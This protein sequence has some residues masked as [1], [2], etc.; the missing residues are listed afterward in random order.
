MMEQ[1]WTIVVRMNGSQFNQTQSGLMQ[2]P[3]RMEMGFAG[4]SL[5]GRL[6]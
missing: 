5:L 2:H 3:L 1:K 4:Q 6:N